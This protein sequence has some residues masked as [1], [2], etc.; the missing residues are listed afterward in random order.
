MVLCKHL[1][2]SWLIETKRPSCRSPSWT[3]LKSEPRQAAERMPPADLVAVPLVA[4]TAAADTVEL[5]V[6][7]P[8]L[9][10]VVEFA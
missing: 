9:A 8:D 4:H 2:R 7:E 1:K 10:L 5:A 6:V 3:L